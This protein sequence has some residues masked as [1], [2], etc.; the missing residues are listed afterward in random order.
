MNAID[1]RTPEDTRVR[2]LEVAWDLFRQL[3]ARTTIADVAEKLGMSSA[4]VYRFFASKQALCEAVCASQLGFMSA[5]AREMASADA[6]AS[7][8][9]RAILISMH[10]TMRDQMLN[11][12]RVHEIVDIAIREN[13]API[14]AYKMEM[15]GIVGTLV[16]EGQSAGEF[17]PG[18]PAELGLLTLYACSGIHH[19][20]LIAHCDRPDML[21]TPEQIVDFALRALGERGD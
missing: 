7:E 17:R 2:I 21:C 14:H 18:D 20:V 10:R 8:R 5:A 6:S 16:A 19:P 15:A 3:G 13:W 11:E 9:I 12:A 4:N 1:R